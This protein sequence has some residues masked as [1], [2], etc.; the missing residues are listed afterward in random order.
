MRSVRQILPVL[1]ALT[2]LPSLAVAQRG[3]TRVIQIQSRG[4][5]GIR[6]NY[7]MESRDGQTT[8]RMIVL[9]VVPGSAADKAGVKAGDEIV[10]IDGKAIS[11]MS[12]DL[13]ARTLEPGDTVRLRVLSGG[14]ERDLAVVATERP[15]EFTLR[16]GENTMMLRGDSIGKMARIYLD[17]ARGHLNLFGDSVFMVPF[18]GRGGFLRVDT[19]GPNR[20]RFFADSLHGFRFDLEA[21]RYPGEMI[22]FPKLDMMM[23]GRGAVAGAEFTELN[24]GLSELAGTDRGLLVLRVAPETP[25]ARAGLHAGDVVTRIGSRPVDDVESL[26]AAIVR[27]TETPLKLEV[28]RKGRT[29]TLDLDVPRARIKRR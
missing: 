7:T 13:V 17:S 24:P 19:I 28:F 26:R 12:Y 29:R 21:M 2:L 10:Q 5:L 23:L 14:R 25:A 22:E 11:V 15:A 27:A 3:Q 20:F 18:R 4:F 1:L 6:N 16:F 8:E 9:E